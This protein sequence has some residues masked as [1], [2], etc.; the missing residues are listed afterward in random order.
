MS[1]S[2]ADLVRLIHRS[3]TPLVLAIT[4]GGSGAISELLREPGA[5]RTVLEAIVPYS[6]ESLSDWLG[7]RPEHFCAG[8]TASAMA[9]AAY[10]RAKHLMEHHDAPA[11]SVAGVACTASLASDRPKRGPHRAHV[12]WQ[13]AAVSGVC[14]LDL[15]KDRRT[16]RE[17]E[18][19]VAALILNS[20]AEACGLSNRL[21]LGLLDGEQVETTVANAPPEWQE[22]LAGVRRAAGSRP[23]NGGKPKAI[24]P[25]AFNPLHLGHR[26]IAEFGQRLLS[27]PV[28]FEISI[29]NVDKPP[30]DFLQMQRRAEQFSSADALWFT[31][32]PTFVEKAV[33]FPG[34]T[35]LVGID[36]LVRIAEPKYYGSEGNCTAAL[37]RIAAL[38]CGFLVFGRKTD[39]GFQ[40]LSDVQLPPVLA[41]ICQEVPASEF[42]EDISSTEL[43]RDRACAMVNEI[44]G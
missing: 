8:P 30:L 9:M 34:A 16:R 3:P 5:S 21:D 17:E 20:V 24:F 6:P 39:S 40:T 12:A 14:S 28:D 42:R 10:L 18:S 22:L 13:M 1:I 31:R 32:A 35:F 7:A 15:I 26:K 36:T 23:D 38:G 4:G 43:R 27:E 41:A 44:D 37:E 33:I 19:A 29:E 25:G 11:W 2:T